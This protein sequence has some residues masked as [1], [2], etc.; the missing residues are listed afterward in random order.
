MYTQSPIHPAK[1]SIQ[2]FLNCSVGNK[3]T[4]S[5]TRKITIGRQ[6]RPITDAEDFDWPTRTTNHRCRRLRL[7]D[8]APG[9]ER[10]AGVEPLGE[11]VAVAVGA[12]STRA[13]RSL[14]ALHRHHRHLDELQRRLA[15]LQGLGQVQHLQRAT[16]VTC[17]TRQIYTETVV[18]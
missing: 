11:G 8:S 13:V 12:C 15:V 5:Q 16:G 14:V 9:E 7:A 3:N 1:A 10:V 2:H 17:R 4:Q 6:E 18:V